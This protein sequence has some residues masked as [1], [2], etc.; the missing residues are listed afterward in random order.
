M[1]SKHQNAA[2]RIAS[3]MHTFLGAAILLDKLPVGLRGWNCLLGTMSPR[4]EIRESSEPEGASL[5][6]LDTSYPVVCH[7]MTL[8][9]GSGMMTD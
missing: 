6:I 3:V 9:A 2:Q 7:V 8:G 1:L 5:A 4:P